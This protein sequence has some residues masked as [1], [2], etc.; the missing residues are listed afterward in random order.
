MLE[1]LSGAS[2]LKPELMEE[3]LKEKNSHWDG[4]KFRIMLR[5]WERTKDWKPMRD[6]WVKQTGQRLVDVPEPGFLKDM[7]V[8]RK[9]ESKLTSEVKPDWS[10]DEELERLYVGSLSLR[11][12]HPAWRK[13]INWLRLD[14]RLSSALSSLLGWDAID[15]DN[16]SFYEAIKR[17]QKEERGRLRLDILTVPQLEKVLNLR[18]ENLKDDYLVTL[19]FSKRF[20]RSLEELEGGEEARVERLEE[21][22]A[23]LKRFPDEKFNAMRANVV[24]ELLA[25]G[26]AA[27]KFNKDLFLNYLKTPLGEVNAMNIQSKKYAWESS[28]QR[29]CLQRLKGRWRNEG[30]P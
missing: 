29:N 30:S 8:A 22:L 11:Q 17:H 26:F 7:G 21:M 28:E 14:Y 5:E 27:G 10:V 23:F 1:A 4:P 12:L 18:K 15:F 19:L 3:I 20:A 2:G 25:L 24:Y 9:E 6:W 16:D 13:K